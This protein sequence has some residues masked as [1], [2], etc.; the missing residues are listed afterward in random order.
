MSILPWRSRRR[1][2]VT[3]AHRANASGKDVTIGPITIANE[4]LWR[5]LPA[6]RF[7]ELPRNPFGGRMS[8]NGEPQDLTCGVKSEGHRFVEDYLSS[9]RFFKILHSRAFSA[10]VQ[11]HTDDRFF[12]REIRSKN[13]MPRGSRWYRFPLRATEQQELRSTL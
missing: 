13:T 7:G 2:P 3:Y 10:K 12:S 8:R 5:M 11:F 6:K 9:S 4:I 1:W